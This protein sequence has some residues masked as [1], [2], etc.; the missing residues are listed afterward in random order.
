MPAVPNVASR[1]PAGNPH[2]RDIAIDRIQLVLD[3]SRRRACRRLTT[4]PRN[5]S[6]ATEL[7]VEVRDA[8]TGSE[9]GVGSPVAVS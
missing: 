7:D 8:V 9:R 5:S 1:I 4:I 3:D 2:E 6:C